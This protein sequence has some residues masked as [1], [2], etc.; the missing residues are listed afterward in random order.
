VGKEGRVKA[1]IKRAR[2][3][4]RYL[5]CA[6]P[7]RKHRQRRGRGRK[8][9]S[10]QGPRRG[11]PHTTSRNMH[12]PASVHLLGG[13]LLLSCAVNTSSRKRASVV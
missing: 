4:V 3:P 5:A 9:P 12:T 8:R 2:H 7:Q 6:R 13:A 10:R 11:G 1:A